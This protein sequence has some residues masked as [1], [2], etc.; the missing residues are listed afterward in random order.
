MFEKLF[1]IA[2]FIVLFISLGIMAAGL[3]RWFWE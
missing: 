2:I 1:E 3:M